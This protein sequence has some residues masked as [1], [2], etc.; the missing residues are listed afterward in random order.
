ML[1]R[2]ARI[3]SFV[4]L[5]PAG[6]VSWTWLFAKQAL[7]IC[8]LVLFTYDERLYFNMHVMRWSSANGLFRSPDEFLE[9]ES[10]WFRVLITRLFCVW[11][12]FYVFTRVL[13]L[14][15]GSRPLMTNLF[16]I[17]NKNKLMWSK[18]ENRYRTCV[19]LPS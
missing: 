10:S 11:A 12:A 17:N 19:V 1:A 16:S 15:V 14:R 18:S 3:S 4:L 2:R 7:S 9:R 5:L 13:S 8:Y 6:H